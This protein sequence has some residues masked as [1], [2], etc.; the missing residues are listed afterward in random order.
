MG[1]T[2]LFT[3][4]KI[5]L[6]Q[7]FQFSVSATI[8]SIQMDP[9]SLSPRQFQH[10]ILI[11]LWDWEPVAAKPFEF[12]LSPLETTLCFFFLVTCGDHCQRRGIISDPRVDQNSCPREAQIIP[13][14]SIL[15]FALVFSKSLIFCDL[16][17]LREH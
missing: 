5:I 14:I 2:V 17:Y 3:H 4:L 10:K 6:L 7:C 15:G 16:K 1:P 13:I 12:F 8:S 9:R 11:A